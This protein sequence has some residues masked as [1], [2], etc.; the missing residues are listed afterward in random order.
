MDL[1][2]TTIIV[3]FENIMG[4]GDF[5]DTINGILT[6]LGKT[7]IDQVTTSNLTKLQQSQV[8]PVTNRLSDSETVPGVDR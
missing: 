4:G 1:D 5:G 6:N 3:D 8:K 2:F 7:I